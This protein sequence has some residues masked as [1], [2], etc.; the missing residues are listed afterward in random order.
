MDE[1][2]EDVDGNMNQNVLRPTDIND[3]RERVYRILCQFE[4]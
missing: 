1:Y 2:I 3:L 4:G